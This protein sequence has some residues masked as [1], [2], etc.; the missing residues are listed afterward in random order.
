[1][2]VICSMCDT[3]IVNVKVSH[4]R[5]AYANLR[6]WCEDPNNVYIARKGIVFIDGA[7][8]PPRDSPF[9]NPYRIGVDG[10]TR[11]TCLIKYEEYIRA[12]IVLGYVDIDTLRDKVLGCWCKP[13][14]CH[15][16]I[17]LKIMGETST[18]P[19]LLTVSSMA[20]VGDRRYTN[21]ANFTAVV[22]DHLS[23]SP[24]VVCLITGD[25]RGTDALVAR[26]AVEHGLTLVE[27][28]AYWNL[29]GKQAGPLRNTSI[30]EAAD[31]LLAFV[32]D[33]SLGSWDSVNKAR[34]KGI[35]V[36]IVHV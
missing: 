19:S 21:Y 12:K 23:L 9:A 3:K 16:D 18:T 14:R 33:K 35:H 20:I 31:A 15:G 4:I 13:D 24:N 2:C 27:H 6:E 29:H 5:P 17:L 36:R 34:K 10:I 1:M 25:C 7:R 32:S 28:P 22:D 8:Y 26:Y 11:E 30:V